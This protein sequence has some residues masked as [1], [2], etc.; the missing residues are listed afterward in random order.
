MGSLSS[1]LQWS[2]SYL[3]KAAMTAQFP[4]SYKNSNPPNP[5]Y[6][7]FCT[8]CTQFILLF[9]LWR[10]A[11]CANQFPQSLGL[12]S[13]GWFWFSAAELLLHPWLL[14]RSLW[15]LTPHPAVPKETSCMLARG[16]HLWTPFPA[17][18]L[19]Q[20]FCCDSCKYWHLPR[21]C[22]C[23]FIP[24]WKDLMFFFWL[25]LDFFPHSFLLHS[26]SLKSLE[27]RKPLL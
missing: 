13:A 8:P 7:S 16:S 25:R 2:C 6:P 21:T 27:E 1:L 10:A 22:L 26:L 12:F 24:C 11:G 20:W 4:H 14:S 3:Y 5:T 23:A 9:P 18:H 19:G 15:M 17:L